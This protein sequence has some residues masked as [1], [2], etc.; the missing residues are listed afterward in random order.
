MI[1]KVI[2]DIPAK[3]V[4]RSFD[5]QVPLDWQ[6]A[7][8]IGSRVQ[9][10]FGNINRTGFVVNII[11]ESHF[12]GNLKNIHSIMD[13]DVYLNE[14]LIELSEYLA[15]YLQAFRISILQAMLPSLLKAKYESVAIIHN[16]QKMEELLGNS[17]QGEREMSRQ[18]LEDHLSLN[19]ITNLKKDGILTM[20]YQV[21]DQKT[22][23]KKAVIQG[24]ISDD[25]IIQAQ[26]QLRKGSHKQSQLLDYLLNT[27]KLGTVDKAVFMEENDLSHAVIRTAEEKGWIKTDYVEV[28]RDPLEG[29]GFE[30][31]SNKQLLAEQQQAFDIISQSLEANQPQ[32]YLIEG[33]TGSGKT[34]IYLQLMEKA[35]E[36]GK[37]ALLLVPEISLTPQM[38]ER[39]VSRFQTGVAVLH[40]G[41]SVTERFDEWQRII[42]KEARIVV[43]A[44]SS[45]FAPLENIG[46][47]IID[48]EH[49]TTYKQSENPRYHARDVAKWRSEYHQ[50]PLVLGSATPSLESRARAQVGNYQLIKLANRINQ[51]PLP[52]VEIIDMTQ[53]PI[54]ESANELSPRL[55]EKIQDRLDKGEQIVL[56]QNRRGYASYMLCRECG[57]IMQCPRCDISLTYHKFDNQMKCHYCDFH[58]AVPTTCPSCQSKHIRTHGIGTQKVAETLNELFPQ[59]KITRMDNDTTRRKGQH[60]KLL[61]EFSSKRTNILLGTQM[62][63]KGLDFENVTLVGVINADTALNLPDFR[64]SERTFQLL[65]QVSGR[66]GRGRL[67]GEVVIQTYNPDHYVIHFAQKHD[68]ENF[69]L[70]EMQRR[71]LTQYPPY[72]FT[73]LVTVSSKYQARASQLIYDLKAQL[74]QPSHES[75]EQVYII[76]PSR[77]NITKI[78]NYYYYH[79]L[80]KYKDKGLIQSQLEEILNQ[81][82]SYVTQGVYVN[83]DHEPLY[84]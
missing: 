37:S 13:Y 31:S 71:H 64:A 39:V 79:I 23:K 61:D 6:E 20:E 51:R 81:S 24:L 59:A 43:G 45:V 73:T 69:F 77:N 82:Q 33:V 8:R 28:Y 83:I 44:R 41:L 4:N 18:T 75:T 40:S 62:I 5:Y 66:T 15:N 7:I 68:Y 30:S 2:V 65:T 72:Y 42:K 58:Q 26:E 56:L 74:F 76:G 21:I 38:V 70:Y 9:V 1:V 35:L 46:I 52:P 48:E 12:D 49:E 50:A 78:N 22:H 25:E 32:T 84:F 17:Y 80:L 3:Q 47:I 53:I 10:P 16:V 14:E 67:S 19:M 60:Q 27:L 29:L 54:R 63:A 36:E 55:I 34:E 11:G 57:F